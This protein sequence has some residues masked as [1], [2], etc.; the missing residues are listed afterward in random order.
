MLL[1]ANKARTLLTGSVTSAAGQVAAVTTSSGA[2]FVGVG[3][4]ATSTANPMRCVITA[5]D[6]SGNDTGAFEIVEIT[7][8]GDNLTL[9]SRGLEGTTAAAWSAGAVIECRSTA[10]STVRDR[11]I[12]LKAGI[13][14]LGKAYTGTAVSL[15]PSATQFTIPANTLQV[16]DLLI[17]STQVTRRGTQN[18]QSMYVEMWIFGT[19][20]YGGGLA[21]GSA[22]LPAWNEVQVA[23]VS[24]TTFSASNLYAGNGGLNSYPRTYFA[25]GDITTAMT[26]DVRANFG[27]TATDTFGLEHY[28]IMI[29]RGN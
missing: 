8:S 5:V 7:R 9:V 1:F 21:V 16:G 12:I 22:S 19:N 13:G 10:D 15:M 3:G 28:H 24:A 6:G 17:F 20:F 2:L 25:S 11:P 23:V 18:T 29:I 4:I 27:A 14:D 26:L